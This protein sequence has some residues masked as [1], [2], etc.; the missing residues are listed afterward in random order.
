MIN[1][2]IRRRENS[3]E[4]IFE[5]METSLTIFEEIKIPQK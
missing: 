3:A 2:N 1:W 4:E 5:E